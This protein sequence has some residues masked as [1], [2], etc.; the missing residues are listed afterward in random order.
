MLTRQKKYGSELKMLFG[1]DLYTEQ[2]QRLM[3]EAKHR[4]PA[5][6][7]LQ[8]RTDG[9]YIIIIFD[10]KNYAWR[11]VEDRENIA[12]VL[13]RLRQLIEETGIGCLIEKTALGA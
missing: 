11:N 12:L 8:T 4:L 9:P 13:L 5:D 6:F 2:V 10:M 3:Y 7:P 1:D